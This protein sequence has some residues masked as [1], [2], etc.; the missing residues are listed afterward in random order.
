MGR[1]RAY[2]VRRPGSESRNSKSDMSGKPTEK[3]LLYCQSEFLKLRLGWAETEAAELRG[4]V[5]DESKGLVKK[6]QIKKNKAQVILFLD[7]KQKPALEMKPVFL[8]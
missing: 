3:E 5:V 4:E 7:Q 6:R 1:D 2:R 8:L